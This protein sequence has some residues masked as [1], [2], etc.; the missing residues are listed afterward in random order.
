[1]G[2][3]YR[4]AGV[5]NYLKN[6]EKLTPENEDYTLSRKDLFDLYEDGDRVEEYALKYK[7]IELVEEPDN[8]HDHNAVRI[9][10]DGLTI[11]Y[12]PAADCRE[13]KGLIR[14]GKVRGVELAEL[15][16]PG[17]YKEISEGD[18]GK[19]HTKQG[20]Y[21]YPFGSVKIRT[22]GRASAST[23]S[24][25]RPG[26]KTAPMEDRTKLRAIAWGAVI[27]SVVVYQ[28]VETLGLILCAIGVIL[29]IVTRRKQ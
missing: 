28:K 7:R 18:D 3:E 23:S 12:I 21:D 11:G 20:K 17:K 13:V 6:I 26:T 2:K 8:P 4:I 27:A 24:S 10:V 25:S 22:D 16:R 29:L 14:S 9:D 19:M 1:M 15:H 5:T